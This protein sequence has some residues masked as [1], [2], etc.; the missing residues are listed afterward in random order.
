MVHELNPNIVAITMT[1]ATSNIIIY[2]EVFN[3]T[4]T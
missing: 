4:Y 3:I 1:E 2:L